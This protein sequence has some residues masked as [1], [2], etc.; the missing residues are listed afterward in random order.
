MQ[1]EKKVTVMK[2]CPICGK[3]MSS[4]IKYNCGYPLVV[5]K[6]LCGYSSE[7]SDYYTT[8]HTTGGNDFISWYPV[9]NNRSV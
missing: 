6:C 3:Y 9:T 1:K 5:F 2:L 8:N 4:E 7:K